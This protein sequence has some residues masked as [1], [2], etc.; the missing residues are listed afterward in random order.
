MASPEKFDKGEEVNDLDNKA[1]ETLSRHGLSTTGGRHGE[2]IAQLSAVIDSLKK[3]ASVHQAKSDSL[4]EEVIALEWAKT[5]E[6]QQLVAKH[7]P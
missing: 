7:R 2:L 6:K 5:R 4:N 3:E 1:E